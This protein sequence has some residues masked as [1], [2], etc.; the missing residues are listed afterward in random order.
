[1]ALLTLVGD[2]LLPDRGGEPFRDLS[3][4]ASTLVRHYALERF[5]HLRLRPDSQLVGRPRGSWNLSSYPGLNVITVVD[6]ESGRPGLR[7]RARRR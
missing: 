7:R 1:M 2:R 4:H 6:G 3:Q 5:A